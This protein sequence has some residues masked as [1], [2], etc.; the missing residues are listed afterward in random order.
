MVEAEPYE[1]I[2]DFREY[3]KNNSQIK[4]NEDNSIGISSKEK[5]IENNKYNSFLQFIEYVIAD[6]S[7][8][9]DNF[10][11]K[12][13]EKMIK[14]FGLKNIEQLNENYSLKKNL[15]EKENNE[16][17]EINKKL[18]KFFGDDNLDLNSKNY[19][20]Y[21]DLFLK[22]IPKDKIIEENIIHQLLKK[23]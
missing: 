16:L 17:N 8:N 19:I 21:K 3:F 2:N 11:E 20:F 13:N 10:Y 12:L 18:K 23:N 15:S 4:L 1:K 9:D 22:Y 14:E 5:L 7:V 6:K